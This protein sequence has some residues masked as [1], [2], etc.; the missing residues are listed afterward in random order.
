[1]A[2]ALSS[3]HTQSF[4]LFLEQ[5]GI[6]LAVSTYQAGK[7]ILLRAQDNILNTHFVDMQK[8]MGM[9]LQEPMLAIGTGFQIVKYF[10]M[11]DVAPKVEPAN[12][13]NSCYLPRDLHITGDIDIHE[14]AFADDG[15]L[16]FINTRMSCLCTLS[17]EHS[18]EP[19]WRPSFI[20]SYDLLDR[21]HLNGLAMRD[22]KP[23]YVSTLGETDNP[24]GWRE[25]KAT[26]GLLIEIDSNRIVSSGISMPHSPR[27]YQDQLWVLESGAGSLVSV[28]L[29]TGQRETI[30]ELPG[31]TRG[32]EFIGR[33]ALIGL[34][35]VR[36]TAVFAGLPLTE[37]CQDRQCGLW[38]IDIVDRQI[39]GFVVF[40]GD[41]QEVF[42]VQI[43]PSTFPALLSMDNPLLR[44]SYSLADSALKECIEP[45]PSHNLLEQ[46]SNLHRQQKLD[47]AIEAY[48]SFLIDYPD[49]KIAGYQLGVAYAD[50]ERWE[51]A[52]KIL[53][54]VVAVA[55]DHAEALNSL[56][57][58]WSGLFEWENA[59]RCYQLAI[60]AD[61][62]YATAHFN[63]SLILLRQGNYTE[64][65]KEYEWRW[66]MPTFT[67]FKCPQPQWQ[68][69][70]ISDKSILIHTEQGNGDAI[71][72]ARFLPLLANRCKRIVVVCPEQLRLF[73]KSIAAVNEVRVPGNIPSDIFDVFSPIMSLPRLL[74]ITLETLPSD[75]PYWSIPGEVIV[76]NLKTEKRTKIGLAWAGSATQAINHHRSLDLTLLLP[77]TELEHIEFFSLQMPLN[78][79]EKQ[80]L[81]NNKITYL[82]QEQVSYAHTGALIQQMDLV[83]SVCTSVAHLSA[84]LGKPTWVLLSMYSDWRWLEDRED[85]PWY[86]NIRL[87]RQTDV[88][89]WL[90]VIRKLSIELASY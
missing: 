78:S 6:S 60:D 57:H 44:S 10:N 58:A 39:V 42:S 43:L 38:I 16:W 48:E 69:E 13:H 45:D 35:Q 28:D 70:D 67:P 15:E 84:S 86:P 5:A 68:G 63:R 49:H 90:T 61:Q 24:G 8:P 51:K 66:R 50:S 79:E 12:T 2:E 3:Q 14:M 25:K 36:E 82:E 30:I 65:W 87:F 74:N 40:S 72:F 76:P 56:G 17:P 71:Q 80:Q 88:G 27:W 22:G 77:L 64:G 20:S 47:A 7:L 62:Q 37:R 83:I 89:E 34:S 4:P 19:R 32:L 33:Y 81:E 31:F 59:L 18:F 46:A 75:I 85:S 11:P 23:A 55:P 1:M 54:R 26:G 53:E 73:F 41:V 29:E 21:C 52:V 9:A